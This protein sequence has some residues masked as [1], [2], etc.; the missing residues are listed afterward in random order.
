M[1]VKVALVGGPDIDHRIDLMLLLRHEFEVLAIGSA[2]KLGEYFGHAGLRYRPYRLLRGVNPGTDILSIAQLHRIFREEKPHVV[3]A[4]DTKPCVLARL[5]ASLAGVPVIVG[6]IPGLGSLYLNQTFTASAVRRLYEPL[7][8]CACWASDVTIFQNRHDAQVFLKNKLV[9][10][11][12]VHIIPGSGVR[13]DIFSPT[14]VS[15]EDLQVTKR[16]LG[17]GENDLVVTMIARLIRSKGIREFVDA[18]RLV[19]SRH[20]HV[21]FQLV[22]PEDR[23]SI[24][25]M[26]QD[27]MELVSKGVNWLGERRDIHR[28]LRVSNIFVF[29]SF[30]PEGIPRVLIEAASVGIPLI[31]ANSPGC[32][33]VVCEGR[34]GFLVPARDSGALA[35]AIETLVEAPTMRQAF[36][37]ASREVALSRFDLCSV[38]RETASLYHRLIACKQRGQ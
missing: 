36:G 13:T 23:E 2:G 11:E 18:A 33:E 25:R 1:T 37:L 14:G 28:I 35:K 29:P 5:A 19:R 22:G 24:D 31:A 8:R 16:E 15:S 38:A 30:Y 3:H 4:F 17:I 34:N 9:P 26:T 21:R 27:E 32:A 7:Q 6:T 12:K 10:V 20:G